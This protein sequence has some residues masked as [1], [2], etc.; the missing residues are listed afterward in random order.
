M[1]YT[2]VAEQQINNQKAIKKRLGELEKVMADNRIYHFNGEF[3]KPNPQQSKLLEA[4]KNPLYKTF[5]ASGSNQ[6]GKTTIGLIISIC[7]MAGEWLWSGEKIEFPH[8]EPRIITYCGQGWETHIQKVVEPDLIRLWP[9]CRAVETHKN[10]QGIQS[11]WIDKKT[12]SELFIMSNNQDSTAFEGDKVDLRV[13]DEPPKRANRVAGGRGLMARNGR[14]L[15]VA[16][17]LSEAWFVREVI[18]AR[19]KNGSPDPTVFNIRGN[20]W[21][22]VSK[23][24]C[25]EMILR[26]T[27][28]DGKNI[29]ECPKCGK[30]TDY[31]KYGL[32][33]EGVE[34][35]KSTLSANEIDVR[36]EGGD[37]TQQTLVFPKFDRDTHTKTPFKIPLDWI[38][39]FSIDFHPNKP[40]AIVALATARNNF[41]YV[42]KEFELRGGPKFVGEE[43]ERYVRTNNIRVGRVTIDPLAKGDK[44]ADEEAL[45]V[46]DKLSTA[47]SSF[48]ISLDVAS[49][50]KSNGIQMVNDL[51]WTE[52]EM[53]GLFFFNDCPKTIQQTEDLMF[54]VESLKETAM[55]VEDDYTEC[56]YRLALLD[57]QWFAE[58]T[59]NVQEQRSVML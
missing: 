40:W 59:Y 24:K 29:G 49:K 17:N 20:I 1:P 33:V 47:L 30:V 2:P 14:E 8:N 44:N 32:T 57:T 39:D 50:D 12:K 16:T 15:F 21:G 3:W 36:L 54:D 45:T 11:H 25:G 48:G 51:L 9:K 46:Y 37:Y 4:W 58:R 53:P 18:K 6:F 38:V 10:N 31:E 34:R 26:E 52:N 41:K 28:V 35:Y 27:V 55:K 43:I 7:V 42:C 5:S 19:L 23:C 56:L 22:N 13:W